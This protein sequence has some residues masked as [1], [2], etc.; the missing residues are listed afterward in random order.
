MA[1]QEM[2]D[3]EYKP[4]EHFVRPNFVAVLCNCAVHTELPRDVLMR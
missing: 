1:L 4:R 2:V 3:M